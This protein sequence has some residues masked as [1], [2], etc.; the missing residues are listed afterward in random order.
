VPALAA[1][2]HF[3]M[4]KKIPSFRNDKYHR[5]LNQLLLGGAVFGVVDHLWNGE[6][7]LFGDKL[8][9]DLLL[10][11]TITVVI[12]LVAGVMMIFDNASEKKHFKT[13]N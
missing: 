1:I 3:F 5:L 8:L 12:F 6:I 2:I 4:R 10:G 7:F 13:E 11:V 9:L